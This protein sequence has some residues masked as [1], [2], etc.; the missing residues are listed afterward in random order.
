M[1][2]VVLPKTHES[3]SL[4]LVSEDCLI[5]HPTEKL[6]VPEG[7]NYMGPSDGTC[8]VGVSAHEG[9]GVLL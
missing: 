3:D 5:M 2:S 7:P 8:P 9:Q 6:V 1:Q 4:S